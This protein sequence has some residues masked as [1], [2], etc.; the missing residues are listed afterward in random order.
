MHTALAR[1]TMLIPRVLVCALLLVIVQTSSIASA[2]NVVR[3]SP[4]NTT[5]ANLSSARLNIKNAK[6][7]RAAIVVPK[8]RTLTL[9]NS[10]NVAYRI[11]IGATLVVVRA[12]GSKT[13][14]LPQRGIFSITCAKAP[15]L[16]AT[17]T[18]K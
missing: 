7:G 8:G 13:I 17:L 12:N 1:R 2:R 18:V 4:S 9:T 16:K 10:D 6:F 15:S 3:S 5:E 11:K 14:P